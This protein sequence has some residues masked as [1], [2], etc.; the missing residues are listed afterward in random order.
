MDKIGK[1]KIIRSLGSGGFADVYQALDTESDLEV[2][3][4]VLKMNLGENPEVVKRF[5]REAQSMEEIDHP[6]VLRVFSH[7]F[8][9]PTNQHY[10]VMELIKGILSPKKEI[11]PRFPLKNK[12]E[13]ILQA[14]EGLHFLHQR[15]LIHRDIKPDNLITFFLNPD[16]VGETKSQLITPREN[17]RT[18]VSDLGIAKQTWA[19]R[20]TKTGVGMG[21]PCYMAPEQVRDS[22][23]VDPQTDVYS[24]GAALYHY[25]TGI[26]PYGELDTPNQV[27]AKKINQEEPKKPREF[28]P[29]IPI[30]LEEIITK[31]MA[32]NRH[33]RYSTVSEFAEDLSDYLG[34]ESLDRLTLSFYEEADISSRLVKPFKKSDHSDLKEMVPV[35]S[36]WK[37]IFILNK[38]GLITIAERESSVNALCSHDGKLY[39]AGDYNKIFETLTGRKVAEREDRVYVLYSHNGQLYDSGFYYGIFETLT[40]RKVAERESFSI[41]PLCSH[42][43]KL[44]D[45]GEG[46]CIFETLTGRKVAERDSEICAL[47]SHDGKLYDAGGDFC[48]FET[49][50]GRKVA[51][52]DS[53]I[54]ALCSHEGQLYDGGFKSIFETL[55]G[56]KVAERENWADILYSYN[57]Q[58]Y[59]GGF[60][61]LFETLTGRK[62]AENAVNHVCLHP[63]RYF[64]ERGIIK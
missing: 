51:E 17:I 31:A 19:S 15:G 4:K 33:R 57:G 27:I 43:G 63:R 26:P 7:D 23:R 38:D 12:L 44:Y 40:G 28:N 50:T 21:T 55:T 39:D 20:L 30:L 45:E 3:I 46:F 52:R 49:L 10:Y 41:S 42:D 11:C 5:L 60:Y 62:V 36:S 29:D 59:D 22:K 8:D 54:H 25:I 9:S 2:A 14:A 1:Y 64:V 18:K 16:E 48:I 35:L 58:L 56:R 13:I 6:N 53:E 32:I 37:T 34:G 47:C 24:L 61:G